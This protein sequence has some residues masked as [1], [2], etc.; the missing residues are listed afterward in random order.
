MM[1]DRRL[2]I[3]DDHPLLAVGLQAELQRSGA[4]VALLDPMIGPEPLVAELT[5]RAPD[6]V[7]LDLGLPFTGGG[8]SLVTPLV[9]RGLRVI[10]LTGQP[11]VRLWAQALGRGAQAVVSKAEPLAEIV[12]TIL[13]VASGQTVRSRQRAEL[14]ADHD[15]KHDPFAALTPREQQVLAGLMDG[16]TATALAD[17]HVVS[18]ATIRAQIR[19]VLVKLGVGSQLEAVALANRYRW[20]LGE[21]QP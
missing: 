11:D 20:C 3:V 19:S 12:E 8:S 13:R 21:S 16:H 14:I 17:D 9:T 5:A 4:E 18:V 10:V 6:G 1:A 7:V 2:V 15:W